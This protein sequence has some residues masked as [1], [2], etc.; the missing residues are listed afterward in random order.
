MIFRIFKKLIKGLALIYGFNFIAV[1]FGMVIPINVLTIILASFLDFF[2]I[3]LLILLK[4]VILWGCY[5]W[6]VYS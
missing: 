2:G 5:E 3:F 1:N 4:N 6:Y